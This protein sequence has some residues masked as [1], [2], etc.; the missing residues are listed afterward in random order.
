[1]SDYPYARVESQIEREFERSTFGE[2][3]ELEPE[4]NGE[5]LPLGGDLDNEREYHERRWSRQG[6][7]IR[8]LVEHPFAGD[9]WVVF[10]PAPAPGWFY[11]HCLSRRLHKG[12][13]YR[14]VFEQQFHE[15]EI[16]AI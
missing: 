9:R 1:M 16:E 13:Q 3:P 12:V 2:P 10:G 6:E 11:C 7:R 4:Y 14:E 5:T 8:I 15:S